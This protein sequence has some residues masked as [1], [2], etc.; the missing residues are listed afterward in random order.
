MN[1]YSFSS[2]AA[3]V[4]CFFLGC[5]VYAKG[6]RL[7]AMS[8]SFA[9]VTIVTGS[10]CLFPFITNSAPTETLALFWGRLIYIAASFTPTLFLRFIIIFL[11]EERK[12]KERS[13]ILFSYIVTI[14]FLINLFN[15][16]FIKNVSLTTHYYR[17]VPGPLYLAFI[18]FFGLICLYA[19]YK[20]LD[21]YRKASGSYRN[22]LR[23][24]FVGF[25]IAF[26]SGILHFLPAFGLREPFPHDVLVITYS[27]IMAYAIV[28]HRLMDINVVITRGVAYS[29]ITAVIAG[30]YIGMLVAV[31]RIFAG[32]PGY[33]HTLAHLLLFIV[34]LFALIYVLPQMK[35]RAI[36]ITR[37][38][39]FR[40]KYEY[41]QEL[42]EATRTIPSMLNLG[43]LGDYILN[44]LRD[45][46]M[47][48]KLSMFVYD[49]PKHSYFLLASLGLEQNKAVKI[50][51]GESSSLV[52]LLKDNGK[53]LVKEELE[54]KVS[55]F[56]KSIEEAVKQLDEL[57][58]E[59]CVPL[60]LK[61]D[62]TGII[63][64]SNKKTGEMYTAE[65]LS[66]LDTLANQ[67]ALTIEYIRAV[68]KLSS[69]KRYV[70]L[71][72]A[73][74]RMAH[75][76]KNPLVPLKTFMQILPDKYPKE[77]KQMAKID[78]EFTGRFY[79][80]AL[81]GIDRIN[82]LIERALHYARHPEPQ[83]SKVEIDKVLDDVLTQE[84]VDM[85]E[86]K[87][88]LQKQYSPESN[89]IEADGEQLMELFANLISNSV[90]AMQESKNKRLLVRTEALNG[91]VLVEIMDSGCGIPQ[92]KID[93]IFDPF[94]T[95]KHTG[96]GLGLAIV[97]KVIDD[98]G[99]NIEVN[100][101]AAQGTTFKVM[102]PRKQT[103][104]SEGERKE[105][106]A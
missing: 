66:L 64:L 7:R 55:A 8:S 77:F 67:V 24:L 44:K 19:F 16:L 52:V 105:Q 41:Q 97:K 96:S 35:I 9:L 87:V 76:I 101:Q 56:Q 80:S 82:L 70:G 13:I 22:Q 6:R 32:V 69:E 78:A 5:F 27:L 54:R 59:L 91:Y 63:A 2:L 100:S 90:D 28:A 95:Y 50:N 10:W 92:D 46:M 71:G 14:F 65:D 61:G 26:I 12:R 104:T 103:K 51:I 98:H 93:T 94:I 73:A 53:P 15:P 23:Y 99:G 49:E 30:A 79:Q 1:A 75:D 37:K 60:M 106:E 102:L 25:G 85:K 74:M 89:S 86:A 88:Q 47:V 81:D 3:F 43:Q 45:T 57:E 72:K 31:D 84:E 4:I 62:L 40:G 18:L 33:N 36:E 39:L 29:A 34:V 20:I 48:D 83:F 38:A 11:N 58:A 68:D 42:S 17:I 21:A